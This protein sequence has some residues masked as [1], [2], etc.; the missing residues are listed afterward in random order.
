MEVTKNEMTAAAEGA[1]LQHSRAYH[2]KD[3][4][5]D[6]FMIG[7]LFGAGWGAGRIA[8]PAL[9]KIEERLKAAS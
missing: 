6:A 8:M 1:W 4:E 2:L 5:K 9:V 3:S 7:F